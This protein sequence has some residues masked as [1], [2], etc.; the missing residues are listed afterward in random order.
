MS[1]FL[2]A[3]F[4]GCM[5]PDDD[6]LIDELRVLAVVAEPPE[7]EPGATV[8]I[9]TYIADPL[10]EP[11]A[12]PPDVMVWTCALL[13]DTCYESSEPG[14]GATVGQPENGTYVT[15]RTA[16]AALIGV[17]N[18]GTTVLPLLLWTL[19][20]APGLCPVIDLAAASPPPD[21]SEPDG[22]TLATFLADPI[23]G[24]EALPLVG[25]SLALADVAVSTRA[26]PITNRVIAP[27]SEA[28]EVDVGG[29]VELTFTVDGPGTAYGYTTRGGFDATDY[30]VNAAPEAAGGTVTL[31]WFGGDEAG[32][33]D[34]W[35]IVNGPMGGTAVWG[36]VGTVR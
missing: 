21:V 2:L 5:G 11:G 24:L 6:T 20:C 10:A 3:T 26:L 16:P 8:Q 36:G 27:L 15:T 28:P 1:F 35:V 19:A 14:Q 23:G 9:T 18:D 7:V 12:A 13:D 30:E 25:T 22:A 17:V 29:A 33:A 32:P 31:T 4:A 34:L